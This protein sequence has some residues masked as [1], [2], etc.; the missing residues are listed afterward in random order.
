VTEPRASVVHSFLEWAEHRNIPAVRASVSVSSW[1]STAILGAGVVLLAG[2]VPHVRDFFELRATPALVI[3]AILYVT[4]VAGV[5]VTR[6][7]SPAVRGVATLIGSGMMLWFVSSLVTLSNTR[8][9]TVFAL[10][11]VFVA[12]Y[13][14]YLLRAGPRYPFLLLP[15]ALGI[16]GALLLDAQHAALFT[17]IAPLTVGVSLTL[18]AVA[19][20][21]DDLNE[22]RERLRE[23][24]AARALEDKTRET[25]R[26]SSVLLDVLGQNHDIGN[27]LA[28]ARVNA[29]WLFRETDD[30]RL[31]LPERADL[32]AMAAELRESLERIARIFAE[33]R[34]IAQD[35]GPM[36]TLHES[37][38]SAAVGRASKNVELR[39]RRVVTV[40]M[41][42]PSNTHVLVRGGPANL[43]RVL[44]NLLCNAFEGDG[45]AGASTVGVRVKDGPVGFVAI[46]VTDDGPGFAGEAL[47]RDITALDTTKPQGSGLGL[48]TAERLVLASGG[49]MVRANRL[50]RGAIVSVT[51]A[52][53]AMA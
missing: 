25:Q 15:I 39:F 47:R 37:S 43:E 53:G 11:P 38:V 14:G 18:G 48:Y 7:A 26:L 42:V 1:T 23:A 19:L 4:S 40:T 5:V 33:S 41:E 28:A 35:M 22:Q 30:G 52:K 31:I 16:G 13:H 36:A 45:K 51:L 50:G 32:H 10:L 6:N 29:D 34:R 3:L 49:R 9:A 21:T 20:R 12:S 8:G 44:E 2:K 17:L 46:E 24:V 27:S